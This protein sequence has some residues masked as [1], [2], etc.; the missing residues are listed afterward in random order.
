[1]E[2]MVWETGFEAN[3]NVFY[4]DGLLVEDSYFDSA[5]LFELL[6]CV[7]QFYHHKFPLVSHLQHAILYYCKENIK[8]ISFQNQR[9][10]TQ[11][12]DIFH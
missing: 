12:T 5:D 2:W 10:I 6:E 4:F 7:G 11:L 9:C 1:M 8:H 3:V